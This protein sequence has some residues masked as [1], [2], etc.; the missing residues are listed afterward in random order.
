MTEK[1]LLSRAT[2]DSARVARASVHAIRLLGLEVVAIDDEIDK[3]NVGHCEIRSGSAS[4]DD[5]KVRH[6]LSAIFKFPKDE[7]TAEHNAP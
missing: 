1:Q 4:L 3:D 2:R 7:G 5:E 6:E